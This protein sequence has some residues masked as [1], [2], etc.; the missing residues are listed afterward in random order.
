[1]AFAGR[2]KFGFKRNISIFFFII[3]WLKVVQF[4][5]FVFRRSASALFLFMNNH[6]KQVVGRVEQAV[7]FLCVGGRA[8]GLGVGSLGANPA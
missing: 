6:F 7:W 8:G 3:R 4:Y 1:M 5:G 2:V